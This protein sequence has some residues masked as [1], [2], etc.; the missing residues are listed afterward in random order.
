MQLK[1]FKPTTPSQ[2][3]LIQLNKSS[4]TK[5]SLL[6]HKISGVQNRAGRNFRGKITSYH[7]GGGH[8][9]KYRI[10]DFLRNYESTGVITSIEYD[11]YRTANIA[12]VFD[13]SNKEYYYIISAKNLKVGNIV[14][15]GQNAEPKIGHSLPILK[16]PIGSYIYNISTR[17]NKKGQFCRAAGTYGQLIEKTTQLARIKLS[18]GEHRYIPINCFASIGIVSNEYLFLTTIGK[19]GRS[20]WLNKRPI[21]RG[22]AMNPIDHPHGGATSGGRSSVTPWGQPTKNGKTSNSKNKLIILKRS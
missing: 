13:F 2:R 14:K 10:I 3:N 18:S 16:I 17:S 15:S 1:I 20:R 22:V 6:K 19:A 12:S 5:T 8:K 21:V 11:P 9:K 4:L 7:R